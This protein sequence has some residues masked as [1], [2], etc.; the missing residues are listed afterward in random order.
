VPTAGEISIAGFNVLSEFDQ[1]R[2]MIGYC[3]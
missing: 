2:R 1:A 3:P